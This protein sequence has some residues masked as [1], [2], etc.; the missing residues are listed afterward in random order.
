[1]ART[2]L[3]L[4]GGE[5]LYCVNLSRLSQAHHLAFDDPQH[6]PRI[7]SHLSRIESEL[8]PDERAAIAMVLIDRLLRNI[9]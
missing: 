6:A 8:D 2:A 1:M 4:L 9:P 7:Q 3:K 5:S